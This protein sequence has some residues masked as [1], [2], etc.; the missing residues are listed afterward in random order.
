MGVYCQ[1]ATQQTS[2]YGVFLSVQVVFA[3]MGLQ[4]ENHGIDLVLDL[5]DAL[6][7]VADV[8]GGIVR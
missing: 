1:K 4:I 6:P 8:G 7:D 5:S 3:K 2:M